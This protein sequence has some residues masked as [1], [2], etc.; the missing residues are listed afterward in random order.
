M[1]FPTKSTFVIP[2]MKPG[3]TMLHFSPTKEGRKAVKILV[4]GKDVL[5]S[6]LETKPGEK[7]E[8]IEIV[9]GKSDGE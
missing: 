2:G 3:Q 8:G 7:I 5:K 6:G 4:G 1:V 9:I